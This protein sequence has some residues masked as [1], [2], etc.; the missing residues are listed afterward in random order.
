MVVPLHIRF[1]MDVQG[2]E[3]VGTINSIELIFH[4]VIFNAIQAIRAAEHTKTQNTIRIVARIEGEYVL[5]EISDNG[6]PFPENEGI[7][8]LIET[9][10]GH[11]LRIIQWEL[12]KIGGHL[13]HIR[14]NADGFK[15]IQLQFKHA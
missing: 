8:S 10:T 4:N 13:L 15:S 11:G 14:T 5:T 7:H 6:I 3:I 1:E 9:S 12:E 2:I